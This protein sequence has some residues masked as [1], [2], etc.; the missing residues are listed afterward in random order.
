[1]VEVVDGEVQNLHG[2]YSVVGGCC[3]LTHD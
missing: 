3:L 2:F 1:L